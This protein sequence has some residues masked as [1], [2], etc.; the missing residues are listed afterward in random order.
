MST[1]ESVLKETRSF[2]PIDAF[3]QNATLS[4]MEAYNTVCERANNDYEGF[5]ADLARELLSWHKPFTRTFDGS[6]APFFKW[7][8]DGLLNVSYNCLDRHLDQHGDKTAIIFES[9]DGQS[10][11]IS[12][13][14]LYEQVCQFA[15]GLKKLGVEKGDR[16]VIYMPMTVQA[17]IAM[18][19]C[20]RIGAIHSVVFGGF[21][22]GA[23][24][25]HHRCRRQNR[26]YRQRRHA[27]RQDRAAE[28][29]R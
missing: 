23:A 9:D 19:A 22:A 16:V 13:R 15:N 14:S 18:Q 6:N 26:H 1:I 11:P 25:P 17:V 8:D 12:Y 4:G 24:R 27:R 3:R 10:T 28:G 29:D 7:F 2:A 21:S 20:A 5:W